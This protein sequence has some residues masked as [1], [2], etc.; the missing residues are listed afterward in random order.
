M[1]N[2][3]IPTLTKVIGNSKGEGGPKSQNLFKG[4]Y[5]QLKLNWKLFPEGWGWGEGGGQTKIFCAG[6]MDISGT[7]QFNLWMCFFFS[8]L[9]RKPTIDKHTH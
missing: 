2:V 6:G 1:Y 8:P 9:S 3:S 7:T 5:I 4:K